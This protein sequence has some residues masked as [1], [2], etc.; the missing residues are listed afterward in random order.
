M[1]RS[2]FL[3]TLLAYVPLA[4]GCV[5][6]GDDECGTVIAIDLSV[7]MSESGTVVNDPCYTSSPNN[8]GSFDV[9]E[10]CPD[11]YSA[12]GITDNGVSV[13]CEEDCG[14]PMSANKVQQVKDAVFVTHAVADATID[15]VETLA[16]AE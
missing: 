2:F 3:L 16:A 11:G 1:F 4:T 5:G 9:T 6:G 8:D 10:C 15:A 12:L 7:T 14:G 13:L